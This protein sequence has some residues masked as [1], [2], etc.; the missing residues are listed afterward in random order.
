MQGFLVNHILYFD[1][2]L[3]QESAQA[4]CFADTANFAD[5]QLDTAEVAEDTVYMADVPGTDSGNI[6]V[7]PLEH[8]H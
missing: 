1:T 6:V 5:Y 4:Q 2:N 3:L 7:V 8:T